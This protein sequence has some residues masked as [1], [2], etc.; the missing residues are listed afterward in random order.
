MK[1]DIHP[2]TYDAKVTCASCGATWTTTSTKKELRI[3]VCSNCHPFFTGESARLLD[4]EGQ[5]DRFYKKLT[6]RQTY[7]EDQK[8]REE[9][10][11]VNNRSVDDLALTPRATD[12][13]KRAGLLTIGKVVEKL[14]EGDAAILAI[15]GFGQSALTATKRK[16]RALDVEL[17]ETPRVEKEEK[18]AG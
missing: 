6:A 14:A 8:A 3:D 16:L 4:V 17:P 2:A 9:S 1:A 11:N 18:A 7:V 10:M 5:V 15:N 12:S 13:L